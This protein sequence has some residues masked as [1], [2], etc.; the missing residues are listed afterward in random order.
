MFLFIRCTAIDPTDKTRLK[1]KRRSKYGG[2]SKL[3]YG[4]ILGQ[5]VVRFF[6]RMER[7]ILR[8]CIRRKYLDQWN[9]TPQIEPLLPF[10]LVV[11]DD[12][13]APDPKED[14]ISFCALCDFEVCGKY[15]LARIW[16][17]LAMEISQDYCGLWEMQFSHLKSLFPFCRLKKTASTVGPATGA[18]KGLITIAG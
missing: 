8:T 15:N 7:K 14:D 9:T 4:F 13:I 1:K 5:I 12:A 11:K 16:S 2:F 17:N 10:P 18:L 6:R 3:N